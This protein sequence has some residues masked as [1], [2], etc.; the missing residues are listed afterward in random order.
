MTTTT[1]TPAPAR[2]TDDDDDSDLTIHDLIDADNDAAVEILER[3]DDAR[4]T[5]TATEDLRD[6]ID[7]LRAEIIRLKIPG[8]LRDFADRLLDQ[9][10]EVAA[11]A[12]ALARK[13]PRASEAIAA[14]GQ[15]AAERHQE[16]A[17][18]TAD[19]GHAAPAEA[20]YHQE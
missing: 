5:A 2:A 19:M 6:H 12:D 14:A 7:Q 13:L 10:G 11:K 20:D 15:K 3:A 9:A 17:D 8:A 4:A 18:T 16:L 1:P